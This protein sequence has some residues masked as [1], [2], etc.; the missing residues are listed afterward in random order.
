TLLE[1]FPV[2]DVDRSTD[3]VF[4]ASHMCRV[5]DISMQTAF[6]VRES[7]PD[8]HSGEIEFV[9]AGLAE[10]IRRDVSISSFSTATIRLESNGGISCL[11]TDIMAMP[12]ASSLYVHS[13]SGHARG[14]WG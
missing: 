3:C 10:N 14:I 11:R 8:P 1:C 4:S 12:F 13:S 9:V 6:V 7:P 5:A 2:P